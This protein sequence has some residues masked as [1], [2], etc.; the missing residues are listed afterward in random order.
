MFNMFSR[1]ILLAFCAALAAPADLKQWMEQQRREHSMPLPDWRPVSN[2]KVQVTD[3][4]RAKFPAIDVHTHIRNPLDR[5]EVKR[6]IGVM[7]AANLRT[8]VH[9]TGGSGERLRSVILA[10]NAYPDRFITCATPD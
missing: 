9:V 8:A 6:I 5:S 7:E 1:T 10:L 4:Q 3:V 2:A